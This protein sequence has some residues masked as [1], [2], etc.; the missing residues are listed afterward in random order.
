MTARRS[1]FDLP[2]SPDVALQFFTPLG[3]M[4]WVPDWRPVWLD[5]PNGETSEGMVF[6]TGAGRE[7]TVWTCLAWVPARGY[8]RYLRVTPATRLAFVDI[9]CRQLGN[10]TRVSVGYRFRALTDEGR[11][12]IAAITPEGFA[13]MID[14]WRAN[15]LAAL[16]RR[17]TAV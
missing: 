12:E 7:R 13:K 14:G 17:Q 2:L 9:R 5:P 1:S 16:E 6:L 4:E 10:G 15:I 3:E 11:S 8:A